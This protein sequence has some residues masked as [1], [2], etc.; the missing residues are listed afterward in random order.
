MVNVDILN[1]L[2]KEYSAKSNELTARWKYGNAILYRMC[3][4]NPYHNDP[5][6]IVGKIW[7][8]GRSYAAA[9]ERRKIGDKKSNKNKNANTSN[10]SFYYDEVAPKMLLFGEELDSKLKRIK[11]SQRTIRDD[12]PYILDTHKSLVDVFENITQ[13]NNRSLASKY[14]HFHC[15]SKFYIYDTRAMDTV[16]KL[17]RKPNADLF[18]DID[19]YD[20]EYGDYVCRVLELTQLLNEKTDLITDPRKV[21]TFLLYAYEQLHLGRHKACSTII[22]KQQ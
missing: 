15:P 16:R 7:L 6:V 9:I 20:S 11:Q 10:D 13:Q 5:H 21:D 17:V 18:E 22:K 3:E 19:K 14:L 8:I 1:D 2:L 12:L 4:E